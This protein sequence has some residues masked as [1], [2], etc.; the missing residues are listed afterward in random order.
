MHSPSSRG[1]APRGGPSLTAAAGV[2][3]G[4]AGEDATS[5]LEELEQRLIQRVK[6]AGLKEDREAPLL[7]GLLDLRRRRRRITSGLMAA[8]C[9]LEEE[10]DSLRRRLSVSVAGAEKLERE[11]EALVEARAKSI[12]EEHDRKLREYASRRDASLKNFAKNLREKYESQVGALERKLGEVGEEMRRLSEPREAEA[13]RL[14]ADAE[15][16]SA[17]AERQAPARMR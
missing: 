13:Q 11:L 14:R 15:R 5:E 8:K 17:R 2:D 6:T 10:R 12:Q 16:Q 9:A 3:D 4:A 7:E 1:A